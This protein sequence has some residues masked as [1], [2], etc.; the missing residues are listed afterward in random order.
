MIVSRVLSQWCVGMPINLYGIVW[1]QFAA[2]QWLT[3]STRL[4]TIPY[5][6]LFFLAQG[7][8]AL[9]R[10]NLWPYPR[11]F[12]CTG[13]TGAIGTRLSLRPLLNERDKVDANL[14]HS[15]SRERGRVPGCMRTNLGRGTAPTKSSAVV[16]DKRAKRA[17]IR[18]P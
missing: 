1:G 9:L 2:D 15:L 11:A 17:P 6:S 4:S 13:P 18:D 12:C 14:G 8:P 10:L 16:P 7:K 5:A 3:D